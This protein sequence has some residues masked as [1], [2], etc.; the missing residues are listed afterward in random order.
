MQRLSS[1]RVGT[2]AGL[3]HVSAL[4]TLLGALAWTVSKPVHASAVCLDMS[5][6]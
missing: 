2:M 1:H 5:P 3:D 4:L 6:T